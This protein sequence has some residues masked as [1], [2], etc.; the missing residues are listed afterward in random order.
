MANE[1]A[2]STN[3]IKTRHEERRPSWSWA[4]NDFERGRKAAGRIGMLV[5][6]TIRLI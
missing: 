6:P 5:K 2:L 1:E 3:I 4:L